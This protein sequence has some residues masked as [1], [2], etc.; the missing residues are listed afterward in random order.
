M[1]SATD[2]AA[3]LN[4]VP[5]RFALMAAAV[6][7][8]CLG[9]FYFA[10]FLHSESLGLPLLSAM[11]LAL[12]LLP[13]LLTFILAS[14]LSRGISNLQANAEAILAGEVERSLE[15]Q[16]QMELGGLA[17][18]FQAMVGRLNSNILRMNVLAYTDAVTGLCNRSVVSHVLRVMS[19]S[20][21]DEGWNGQVSVFFFDLDGFKRV[22][23]TLGHEAGDDLLR[24]VADRVIEQGLGTERA[25]LAQCTTPFGELSDNVPRQP[26]F[27][28][29][30]GDEFVLILP[31]EQKQENLECIAERILQAINRPFTVRGDELKISASVGIARCPMDTH[32]PAQL[33]T[34]ADLAMYA[35]KDS[36]KN[37]Y[38]F[39]DASL[40]QVAEE[41][42]M[43]ESDL[44][45]GIDRDELIL[46]FQPK[47]DTRSLKLEG[48]EA[49]IRWIHPDQGMLLPHR[50][51]GVAEQSGLMPELGARV[52]DL[53]ARQARHWL[54]QG[55]V[56]PIAVNV[57][58]AQ[59]ER[60]NLVEEVM[61]ALARHR[62]DPSLL[63][64]EISESM[65]M[66]DFSG[67]RQRMEQLREAGVSLSIDDFGTGYSNLARLVHLPF[68]QLKIDRAL[69][70]EIGNNPKSEAIVAAVIHMAHA[71]GHTVVAEGIEEQRQHDFLY[72]LGCDR[73][74]GHLFGGA[75]APTMLD[76]WRT[77]APTIDGRVMQEAIRERLNSA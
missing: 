75:M 70:R 7:V 46:H 23:D 63:E 61:A 1:H 40:R 62:V 52:L 27:V 4:K 31:G 26:V 67:T 35:A 68:D 20:W 18:S 19:K 32:R 38:R 45:R 77:N 53:A 55:L 64:I 34:Y 59:F 69:V 25:G 24:M 33:L 39:F 21:P 9:V 41:R 36:G 60:P 43:I 37:R 16:Q 74:Q 12:V 30:A 73:V 76:Q 58:P 13:A 65:A 54:D 14:R 42:I 5:L 56:M 28:R 72:H 66:S 49:L 48:V 3:A 50:F 17:D 22:N 44:R 11:T 57:S 71:L 47:L 8:L 6:T 15:P 51:I 2:G 10:I 29:F